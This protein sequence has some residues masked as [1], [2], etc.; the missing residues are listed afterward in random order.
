MSQLL[1]ENGYPTTRMHGVDKVLLSEKEVEEKDVE[2]VKDPY[3]PAEV[4][5]PNGKL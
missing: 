5:E 3:W 2:E 1:D 4:H